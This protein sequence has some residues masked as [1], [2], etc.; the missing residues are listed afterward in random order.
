M[1]A[2]ASLL[3]GLVDAHAHL[4]EPGLTHKE[5]FSSAAPHAAALGGVTTVLDM[6]TDEPW[7][8]DA[9]TARRQDGYRR[10]AA[11]M[12]MSASRPALRRDLRGIADLLAL[13]PVSFEL[14][15]ADVPE[16]AFL[17][18]TL[19]AVT[20]AMRRLGR[21]RHAGRRLRRAINRCSRAA[22]G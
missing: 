14:F 8:A 15:T 19:A 12:S 3:P 18:D 9:A 20:T 6:P 13:A 16:P 1:S 4:R 10:K 21:H 11:C 7:T 22:P 2:A 5:D 17:I